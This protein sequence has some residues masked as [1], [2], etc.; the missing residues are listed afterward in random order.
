[1]M[2]PHGLT[3]TGSAAGDASKAIWQ[4]SVY[5]FDSLHDLLSAPHIY[6]RYGC[7]NSDDLAASIASLEGAESGF[8]FLSSPFYLLT[9]LYDVKK[10]P[11]YLVVFHF[12]LIYE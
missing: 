11:S 3:A 9:V 1:M 7:P 12:L 8:F 10:R 5:E 4:G 2:V 6:R